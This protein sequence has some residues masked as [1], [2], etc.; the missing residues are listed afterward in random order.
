MS[1]EPNPTK[2]NLNLIFNNELQGKA[3]VEIWDMTGKLINATTHDLNGET[4]LSLEMNHMP[5]S[6]YY[7][8]VITGNTTFGDK[9]V[10]H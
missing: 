5:N 1:I 7:I 2:G 6:T 8:R 3:N 10:K 9:V 4:N